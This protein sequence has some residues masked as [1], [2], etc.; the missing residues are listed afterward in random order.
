MSPIVTMEWGWEQP[1]SIGDG[2]SGVV[3]GRVTRCTKHEDGFMKYS[4]EFEDGEC[5]D[6]LL[7]DILC[8]MMAYPWFKYVLRSCNAGDL[9]SVYSSLSLSRNACLAEP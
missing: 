4:V 8:W 1:I 7:E 2:P 9:L 5:A 3:R 6:C